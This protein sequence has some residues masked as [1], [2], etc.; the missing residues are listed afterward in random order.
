ML[1]ENKNS[2]KNEGLDNNIFVAR[3]NKGIRSIVNDRHLH[4][5]TNSPSKK[6]PWS[7][8]SILKVDALEGNIGYLELSVWV[9]SLRT[10]P[11][12]MAFMCHLSK[13]VLIILPVER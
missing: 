7:K 11:S 10:R 3:V 8:S 2:K 1:K 4:V 5:M 13:K 6:L 9:V 12:M